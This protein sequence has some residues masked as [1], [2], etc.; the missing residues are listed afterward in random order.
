MLRYFIYKLIYNKNGKEIKILFEENIIDKYSLKKY[1][2]F[3]S[4]L[5]KKS[6]PDSSK[7]IVFVDS[8]KSTDNDFKIFQKEFDLLSY[9]LEYSG[10]KQ[11]ELKQLIEDNKRLDI[12]YS[13]FLSKISANLSNNSESNN[14]KIKLL[15]RII[16]DNFENKEK[17]M[18]IFNLFLDKS[19]YKRAKINST[20]AEI[21]QYSLKFCLNSDEI[22]SDDEN[23][24]YPLY[25]DEDNINSYIPGNDIKERRIYDDY[26]KIKQYLDQKPSDY[27]VYICTC[28]IDEKDP[29]LYIQFIEGD[30]Y[31]KKEEKCKNCEESTGYNKQTNSFYE[32]DSYYRIF[33]NENDLEKVSKNKG[34]KNCITLEKFYKDFI[35]EKIEEDS[36]GFNIFKRNHFNKPNKPIRNQSQ[37]GYRL[38]NLISYSHLF[39]NGLFSS[40]EEIFTDE[41]Y[42]Y[43]DYIKWNWGK[44]KKLLSENNIK[45]N[46]YIYEF[47]IQRFIQLFKRTKKIEN[48]ED[49]LK[50]E[51]EIEKIIESKIINKTEKIKDKFYTKYNN[52]AKF[53]MK[54]KDIFRDKNPDTK[55][56]IIKEINEPD[57]YKEKDYPYNKNFLYSDYPNETLMKNK[58]EEINKE[59]YP[60]ID[61]CLNKKNYG[62]TILDFIRI[63]YALTLLLNH[64][65]I[66]I[67]LKYQEMMQKK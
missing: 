29:E 1:T 67:L 50:V 6:I 32:R 44:L 30:G 33:K 36:K 2:N 17:L 26:I 28:N 57:L 38:M 5:D 14:E 13:V 61:L 18:N 4:I 52:F 65:L 54:N 7:Y 8:D 12:F 34:N 49:L 24:Y 27:G 60:V 21:L 15:S 11:N 3:D 43:L 16:E 46:I 20:T 53:Y 64:C 40:N 9:C 22:I 35:P 10:E 51:G 31:P 59:S 19:K 56:S 55:T 62:N 23:M 48:Y 66:N 25:S 58:L 63:F 42:S 37:I 39:T 41:K 47:N 45:I